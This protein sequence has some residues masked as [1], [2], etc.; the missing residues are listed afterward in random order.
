MGGSH[1]KLHEH[2]RRETVALPG[3]T[4]FTS[5]VRVIAI[6][7][8]GQ[9]L[10]DEMAML[11]MR[12]L[13]Y[14]DLIEPL[15]I[16]ATLSPSF[17]RARLARGTLDLIGLKNV[18]IGIGTDGGDVL[19][20]H[21]VT[22]ETSAA[23]YMPPPHAE[24]SLALQ[25]GRGMLHKLYCDADPKSLTLVIIASLKDP[26]LFLRDNEALF[27]EKTLEVVIMG[28]VEDWT[29]DGNDLSQPVIL[30]PDQAHNNMFDSAASDFFYKR[31][32]EIGIRLI[33]VS[34]FAAYPA[35]MPRS[36]YD[37][38]ATLGSS[39][40]CRLR[41]AQ[42]TSIEGLWKR[43]CSDEPERGGLPARCNRDWFLS[44]FC[45]GKDGTHKRGKDDSI[46]DLV[47]GFNQYDTLAL[48]AAVPQLRSKFFSPVPVPS[49]ALS[50][51]GN[52]SNLVIGRSAQDHGIKDP[53]SLKDL[54]MR[55]FTKG[56]AL[57]HHHKAY[58]VILAQDRWDTF[59]DMVLTCIMLRSLYELGVVDCL[60][61][62]VSQGISSEDARSEPTTDSDRPQERLSFP[63]AFTSRDAD[64]FVEAAS[65]IARV[66][67]DLG[68]A[69]VPVLCCT[70]DFQSPVSD[71][72]VVMGTAMHHLS[73]LYQQAPPMGL[74]LMIT[75]C[76]TEA[77]E[78]A[79]SNPDI[80]KEKTI[81]VVHLGGAI[82]SPEQRVCVD[83]ADKKSDGFQDF[84]RFTGNKILEPDPA[85]SNNHRDW[86]AAVRLY[87]TLQTYSVPMIVLSRHLAQACRVPRQLFD[88][89]ASH[90]GRIGELAQES[91]KGSMEELWNRASADPSDLKQRRG[92]AVRCDR[93]WFMRTFCSADAD[94]STEGGIWERLQCFSIYN[95]LALLAALPLSVSRFM[96]ATYLR[97]RSAKHTIIGLSGDTPGVENGDQVR[98]IVFQCLFKGT[99]FNCSDFSL[100]PPPP[101]S[102]SMPP[103]SDGP[104][105]EYDPSEEALAWLRPEEVLP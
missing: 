16:V 99:R 105:W 67:S 57:D 97:V 87:H 103:R 82:I 68:L 23:S 18:P 26:A 69:H 100:S 49:L 11:M 3:N 50:T 47:V 59:F 1:P 25:P 98:A 29:S 4:P 51:S 35:Q 8:P 60:G 14:R 73:S 80:F 64:S 40:G 19:G 44:T 48:L 46:W 38:L 81:S 15:G 45:D 83:S 91:C 32:Q 42:R 94:M 61:I 54:L 9:D 65:R 89:L 63:G 53:S 58:V 70:D 71:Q 104:M 74:T 22:F 41:N 5:P 30:K 7:D 78:F 52:V 6:S 2:Q 39:I 33:I 76:A 43:A 20:K 62:V 88:A 86:K 10:D 85:A 13:V 84:D 101:L 28:G 77:A 93:D 56:L 66:L 12:Y 96:Q 37:E 24:S 72:R 95:P 21:K 55:G 92:L 17:D 90:G 102:I 31:C 27:T 34:R 75:A 36:V 79:E